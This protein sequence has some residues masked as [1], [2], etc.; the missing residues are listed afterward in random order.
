MNTSTIARLMQTTVSF[1]DVSTFN[2]LC[3][4]GARQARRIIALFIGAKGWHDSTDFVQM[5]T[6]FDWLPLL[7]SNSPNA[8]AW[9]TVLTR[10]WQMGRSWPQRGRGCCRPGRDK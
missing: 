8:F 5:T 6:F 9:A 4:I 2:V 7:D 10:D 1:M 3:S